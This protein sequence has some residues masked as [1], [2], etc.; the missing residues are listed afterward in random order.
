MV[1]EQGSVRVFLS[2]GK[3]ETILMPHS[4]KWFLAIWIAFWLLLMLTGYLLA[5]VHG[6]IFCAAVAFSCMYWR[7]VK[8][9][10][11]K[12]RSEDLLVLNGSILLLLSPVV[13]SRSVM[14]QTKPDT[15][16]AKCCEQCQHRMSDLLQAISEYEKE[17]GTLP[18]AILNEEGNPILS[19]RVRICSKLDSTFAYLQFAA[20]E[21][22]NSKTN[23]R[24]LRE[25]PSVFVCPGLIRR[26]LGDSG[27]TCYDLLV[28]DSKVHPDTL[29][30]EADSK[31]IATSNYLL[32]EHTDET[33][34]W[35]SPEPYSISQF[36][37]Q[38]ESWKRQHLMGWNVGELPHSLDRLFTRPIWGCN[39]GLPDG[40]VQL[41]APDVLLRFISDLENG[42]CSPLDLKSVNA[43][44]YYGIKWQ[45]IFLLLSL[46][47]LVFA[48]RFLP[49]MKESSFELASESTL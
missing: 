24:D 10:S 3:L 35:G 17:N 31:Q 20:D 16:V 37:S 23:R 19:W 2:A 41:V 18:S 29:K 11:R 21:P 44:S 33:I 46:V 4:K 36:K 14:L 9:V 13:Q 39:V 28:F 45:R 40:T 15:L 25:T 34:P 47:G 1:A 49:T 42:R 32:V 48:S 26:H 6:V 22:W 38:L 12:K 7:L 27:N 30:S 5:S 8:D 43:W